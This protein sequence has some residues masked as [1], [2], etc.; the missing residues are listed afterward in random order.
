MARSKNRNENHSKKEQNSLFCSIICFF[1]VKNSYCTI[2]KGGY[3][4]LVAKSIIII[5]QKKDA[6]DE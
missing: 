6:I 4:R 1:F 5:I 3:I 2:K